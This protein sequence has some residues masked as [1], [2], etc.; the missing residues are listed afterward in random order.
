MSASP[1]SIRANDE[2][3]LAEGFF[4]DCTETSST[5]A[6][7]SIAG[8]AESD[9]EDNRTYLKEKHGHSEVLHER[10]T[11]LEDSRRAPYEAKAEA[12]HNRYHE[13]LANYDVSLD[14]DDSY[15]P[16]QSDCLHLS[17][18]AIDDEG[19]AYGSDEQPHCHEHVAEAKS[20]Q[21]WCRY[22]VDHPA[23]N[24]LVK[25]ARAIVLDGP[26]R[27]L[28]LPVEIRTCIY[29]LLLTAPKTVSA[30]MGDHSWPFDTRLL[31][32]SR[33]VY[34]EAL[35]AFCS[36]NYF[37]VE[38][39]INN[40]YNFRESFMKSSTG[41]EPPYPTALIRHW[42]IRIFC[43]PHWDTDTTLPQMEAQLKTLAGTLKSCRKL[44]EIKILSFRQAPFDHATA[45]SS[46]YLGPRDRETDRLFDPLWDILGSVNGVGRAV[47]TNPEEE[48]CGL[49]L[50]AH[51]DL[52]SPEKR[53]EV[54]ALMESSV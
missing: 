13:E 47:F 37:H 18:A 31:A 11:D 20:K 23:W 40:N 29:K 38:T 44:D 52:G 32:V 3:P 45:G 15:P 10:W 8:A 12:D 4:T 43:N 50:N 33:Q 5:S 22:R 34:K 36:S 16:S 28:D 51:T 24:R 19:S 21:R 17:S 9:K 26:F 46:N 39:G 30:N 2:L 49:G 54:K 53:M 7:S 6:T 41:T 48:F 27:F 14:L 25:P 42:D 1:T 35:S